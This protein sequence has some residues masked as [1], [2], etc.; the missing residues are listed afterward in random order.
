MTDKPLLYVLPGLIG[1]VV[2]AL[3]TSFLVGTGQPRVADQGRTDS[4]AAVRTDPGGDLGA[5]QER[6]AAVET[7]LQ[8][9]AALTPVDRRDPAE[10]DSTRHDLAARLTALEE[11]MAALELDRPAPGASQGDLE[12]AALLEA[13]GRRGRR[14]RMDEETARTTVLDGTRTEQEKL[15]AWR[16]LRGAEEWGDTV[17]S[18]MIRLGETSEDPEIRADVWRQADGRDRNT[19]L[20]DPMLRALQ[21]DPSPSVRSE[22]AETLGNYLSE[23]G[24]RDALEAAAAHDDSDDVRDEAKSSLEGGR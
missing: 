3:T 23:P 16:A 15:E 21:S 19:L 22:A 10:A 8:G 14:G 6:V 11:R 13:L 1:A 2:G 18:E 5:L 7:G 12:R 17:V 9:L 20:V 24:V 4:G